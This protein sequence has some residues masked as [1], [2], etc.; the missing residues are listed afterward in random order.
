MKISHNGW[1]D[2]GC[3]Q[4]IDV[5]HCMKLLSHGGWLVA[6]MSKMCC[7]ITVHNGADFEAMHSRLYM[8]GLLLRPGVNSR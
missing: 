1:S 2:K 7:C 6:V 4:N 3:S 5:R 8:N